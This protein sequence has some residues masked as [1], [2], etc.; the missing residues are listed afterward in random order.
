[1]PLNEA[2]TRANLI[3]PALAACGWTAD[4]IRREI[5]RARIE[6]DTIEG[7]AKRRGD[8]RI[9]YLLR[10][11]V[12]P[13]TQPV[14]LALIEAKAESK[15]AAHGLEQAKGYR[16]L[17]NVP[18]VF[19]SNGHLYVEYD[20]FTGL[21]T[22]P[23]PLSEFPSPADL[24][25][26]YETGKGF[27]L[28]AP[29]AKA[30]ITPYRGG[31]GTRRYYQDAAI[32][33]VLEKIAQGHDRALLTLATGTGKTFIATNLL[34]RIAEAGQLKRALFL[35]DR[36]ELRKQGLLAM[37]AQFGSDAAE[38][39]RRADG[40]NNA[41]NAR[42]H[43]ATYQ[44]LGV[45]SDADTATFLREFYPENYFS[46][47]VIDECHRS[48]W[49]RWFEVLQRNPDAVH[50]GLTAT[51]RTLDIHD[52][53]S[54][55]DEDRRR[56]ADNVSYFG[57]PVYAYDIAQGIE[58]GY[59]AACEIV[60]RDVFIEEEDQG[61]AITG[62][63]RDRLHDKKLSW[64]H[65]GELTDTDSAKSHYGAG[66]FETEITIPERTRQMAQDLFDNL[67]ATGG[68]EQKTIVFCARDDH[69]D[70]VA[71]ALNNIYAKWAADNGQKRAEPFAFKC[72]AAGGG[73]A[74][75][76]DF[77]GAP[78]SHFIACTVDLLTT[79]VD[80]PSLR[81]VVFM[82]YMKSPISFYQMLGRGTRIDEATGKLMF[83]VYD[84]T[85]AT[86]LLG[87]EFRSGAPT[88]SKPS[89]PVPGVGGHDED[90]EGQVE[91]VLVVEGM[92]VRIEDAGR[93]IL[94]QENG[95][96][97]RMPVEEYREKLAAGLR[98]EA[99]DADAF[100]EIWIEP[101]QRRSLVENLLRKGL[102]PKV[103]Q[104][105][106]GLTAYDEYDVL[107]QTAY[108]ATPR[109]RDDRAARFALDNAT[110]LGPM[111]P[112]SKAAILALTQQFARGGTEELETPSVLRVPA[113]AR[114]G[115]LAA[116]KKIGEPSQV[117]RQ[118]RERLFAA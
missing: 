81:N 65:S 30:L 15:A 36:D 56:I 28:D 88:G 35:C 3:D 10:Y 70:D 95:Q 4:H 98:A 16:A 106:D 110:W 17:H 9:D 47:I 8:G 74:L 1:M 64:R 90:D 41:A 83:R 89:A 118:T 111:P 105:V 42:V 69:A 99:P 18:F 112:D 32:R 43:V 49:N 52:D 73:Q 84:Y 80:V 45:D 13:G 96:D 12:N 20:N 79:G 51:P 92:S 87:E 14:P 103:I 101:P 76:P 31:E 39:Y 93:Y 59:L 107:A 29:Q 54:G 34:H 82:R 2:D 113:V 91:T 27:A 44:T 58:D 68:P 5:T 38:V 57:E 117:L 100:R 50:I 23:K 55:V 116:L 102:A 21:T 53:G 63:D 109:T 78:R 72:T 19:S 25:A 85:D 7:K 115:G 108:A 6:I 86:R 62:L 71:T 94:M 114:V 67:L 11:R 37:S 75:L 22:E 104:H 46:H 77:K 48:A 33:A 60:R 40:R 97:I 66:Q 61:E 26:R 24:R